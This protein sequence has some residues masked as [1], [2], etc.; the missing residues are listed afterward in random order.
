MHL[1][2]S[3]P[4][5]YDVSKKKSYQFWTFF[6]ISRSLLKNL[7][8]FESADARLESRI[9]VCFNRSVYMC[10]YIYIYTYICIHVFIYTY[11]YER[12]ESRAHVKRYMNL[13]HMCA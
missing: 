11:I 7:P 10:V 3:E 12:V 5:V 4:Q 8:Q 9:N 13:L 1:R 2:H 6:H